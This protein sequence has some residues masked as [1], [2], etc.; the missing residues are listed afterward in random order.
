VLGVEQRLDP[1]A[2]AA[3]D[4]PVISRIPQRKR[5]LTTKMVE[6]LGAVVFVQ[7]QGDLTV[8]LRAKPVPALLEFGPDP[9]EIVELAVDDDMDGLVFIGDRLVTRGEVDDREPRVTQGNPTIGSD[10]VGA[11]IWAA[12]VQHIRPRAHR[13]GSDGG[14]AGE[15]GSDSAHQRLGFG[16]G[17]LSGTAEHEV[18]SRNL[19]RH[20]RG[21]AP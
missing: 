10:P 2:I 9:L 8:R 13:V 3:R 7:V 21:C 19:P 6:A 5:V 17:I 1:E 4:Q 16:T 18:R 11:S 14:V 12:V 15:N 20:A